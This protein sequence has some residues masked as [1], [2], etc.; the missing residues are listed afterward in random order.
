MV[1]VMYMFL[2]PQ[3]NLHSSVLIQLYLKSSNTHLGINKAG[4]IMATVND[5]DPQSES[6]PKQHIRV[7]TYI[8]S[9]VCLSV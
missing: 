5:K 8:R 6:I 4:A 2:L 3:N 1:M 9:T 7:C